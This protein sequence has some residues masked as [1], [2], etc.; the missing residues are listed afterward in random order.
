[1]RQPDTAKD[2]RGA[3]GSKLKRTRTDAAMRFI[4]VDKHKELEGI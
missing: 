3:S 4:V 2:G 1:M